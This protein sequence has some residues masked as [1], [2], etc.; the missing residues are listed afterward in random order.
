MIFP[1][2]NTGD[3]MNAL[4]T[5]G[6]SGIGYDLALK[7]IK[8]GHFVYLCVHNDKEIR[9]VIDK[10][11][12]ISYQDRVSVIKLDILKKSNRKLI[13]ALDIDCLVLNAAVGIGGSLVNMDV[14]DIRYNF[15]VNFFSNLE[16]IKMYIK[17]RGL[18]KSKIVVVS[19]MAGIFSIPFL[20]SYCSSKAALSTFVTCLKRELD[21]SKLNISIK[22]IEPGTYKTGFNQIMIDNKNELSSTLFNSSMTKISS[23]QRKL[24]SFLEYDDLSSVSNKIYSAIVSDN[25]KLMYRAPLIQSVFSKLY[26]LFVK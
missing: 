14:D 18:K 16:M 20:G 24:F 22:I 7:L 9:T 5:G 4:I 6:T 13:N 15:E 11:K 8:N 3:G 17:S 26:M 12:D 10:L 25:E 23:N 1:Y 19:S 2:T 21:T